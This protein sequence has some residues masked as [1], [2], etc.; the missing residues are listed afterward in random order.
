MLLTGNSN[1]HVLGW[2]LD[3]HSDLPTPTID[4][5]AHDDCTNGLRYDAEEVPSI[6]VWTCSI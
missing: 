4:F 2:S 5:L 6:V 3:D 1:G